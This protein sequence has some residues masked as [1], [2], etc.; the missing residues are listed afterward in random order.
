MVCGELRACASPGM[1][2]RR[3]ASGC[4][5]PCL[6]LPITTKRTPAWHLPPALRLAHPAMSLR[7]PTQAS[8]TTSHGSKLLLTAAWPLSPQSSVD[9]RWW[10]S[11]FPQTMAVPPAA[12]LALAWTACTLPT[13]SSLQGKPCTMRACLVPLQGGWQSVLTVAA[14][15]TPSIHR[16]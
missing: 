7:H 15:C 6:G 1:P 14:V 4:Q 10:S 8:L 2:V 11:R 13:A 12:T 16:L 5:P 9:A 3:L